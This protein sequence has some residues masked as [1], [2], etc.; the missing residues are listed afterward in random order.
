M[1]MT[2]IND[3][4]G[5]MGIG[6]IAGGRLAYSREMM[7]RLALYTD[8]TGAVT[9][10][11]RA[12]L[13]ANAVRNAPAAELSAAERAAAFDTYI[14]Q[15]YGPASGILASRTAYG[16]EQA[17]VR[18]AEQQAL[19]VSSFQAQMD[20]LRGSYIADQGPSLT[21]NIDSIMGSMGTQRVASDALLKGAGFAVPTGL[22]TLGEEGAGF[23]LSELAGGALGLATG[24]IGMMAMMA[25]PMIFPNLLP[26]IFHGVGSFF[27]GGPAYKPTQRVNRQILQLTS[28]IFQPTRAINRDRHRQN[29]DAMRALRLGTPDAFYSMLS[30]R[31]QVGWDKTYAKYTP[32]WRQHLAAYEAYDPQFQQLVSNAKSM[33]TGID[34]LGTTGNRTQYLREMFNGITDKHIRQAIF[35][36]YGKK[37]TMADLAAE[38]EGM[39]RGGLAAI[40]FFQR[41]KYLQN[42]PIYQQHLARAGV[43]DLLNERGNRQTFAMV[44]QLQQP[45]AMTSLGPLKAAGDYMAI[46][47]T[48]AGLNRLLGHDRHMS[49][50]TKGAI[51]EGYKEASKQIVDKIKMLT[52]TAEKIHKD[53]NLSMATIRSLADEMAKSMK[54]QN[55]SIKQDQVEAAFASALTQSGMSGSLSAL[56]GDLA[57]IVALSNANGHARK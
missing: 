36:Q 10:A 30:D 29:V 46:I 38:L 17:A 14:Q 19:R 5:T 41:S 49:S 3:F 37:G 56:G 11:G 26:S 48:L 28:D 54:A 35:Q 55:P 20:A 16:A 23:G 13:M 39:Q 9:P 50:T 22:A 43:T 32:K 7:Q 53:G 6:R 33:S 18:Q 47:Q 45:H 2:G 15:N 25:L 12:A 21:S 51:S 1:T 31:Q 52:D 24:P 8:A 4:L 44:Q 42:D 40:P 34:P 27:S 57:A